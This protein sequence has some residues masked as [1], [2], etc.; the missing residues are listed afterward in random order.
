MGKTWVLLYLLLHLLI[1]DNDASPDTNYPEEWKNQH[2]GV[3]VSDFNARR[4]RDSEWESYGGR[5]V[6]IRFRRPKYARTVSRD[7]N[8]KG[9]NVLIKSLSCG[10]ITSQIINSF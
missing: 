6:P 3:S 2:A 7:Q 1:T 10:L 5:F 8:N 4:R 9:K